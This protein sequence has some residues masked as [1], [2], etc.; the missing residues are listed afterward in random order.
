MFHRKLA[1]EISGEADLYEKL[2]SFQW[3]AS[4]EIDWSRQIRNFSE[5]TYE[6]VNN[7][8]LEDLVHR[9]LESDHCGEKIVGMQIFLEGVAVG[10]FQ[11]FQHD[12]PD[13]LMRDILALVL[14]DESRHAGFGVIHLADRF[15]TASAPERRWIE[16]FVSDLWRLF[17]HATASP[18]GPVTDFLD[19]TFRDI[20]HR[21]NVIGLDLRV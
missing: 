12:S 21:L 4:T 14:R 8:A 16:D 20:A 18:F 13:P 5:E 15:R 2:K 3:N 6:Q 9:L 1:I 7:P 11:R 19:S 17:H 10:I